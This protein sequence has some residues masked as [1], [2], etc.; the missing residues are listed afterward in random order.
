MLEG[1]LEEVTALLQGSPAEGAL[2]LAVDAATD[3][4]RD[5]Q[6][7]LAKL[8]SNRCVD[9]LFGLG[10]ALIELLEPLRT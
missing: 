8:D 2:G 3:L 1:K 5:A 9:S 6:K 10:D 7:A 4:I